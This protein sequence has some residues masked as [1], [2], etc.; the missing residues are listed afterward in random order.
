VAEL[1]PL[2]LT[3]TANAPEPADPLTQRG[4]NCARPCAM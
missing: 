4:I 1:F 2:R 3:R